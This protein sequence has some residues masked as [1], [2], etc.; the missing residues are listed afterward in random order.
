ML[1]FLF[2][3]Y[4][5]W[6]LSP[7]QP[8]HN[9]TLPHTQSVM[10]YLPVPQLCVYVCVRYRC[11]LLLSSLCKPPARSAAAAAAA[12]HPGGKKK[13]CWG[14]LGRWPTS[15]S[16]YNCAAYGNY[17]HTHG[18]QIVSPGHTALKVILHS[19]SM[20]DRAEYKW[21]RIETCTEATRNH[22]RSSINVSTGPPRPKYFVF[23][24][25]ENKTK[26]FST[27][28]K[29]SLVWWAWWTR[30]RLFN[31]PSEPLIGSPVPR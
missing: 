10:R 13:S 11:V 17:S 19:E 26:C 23:I 12:V 14:K 3:F 16:S 5:I 9:H 18:C 6:L 15:S 20:E 22:H 21:T 25:E 4:P 31:L 1:F 30:S 28:H 29:P 8:N 24:P 2:L 27:G 7:L